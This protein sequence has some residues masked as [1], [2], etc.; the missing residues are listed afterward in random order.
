[1][2]S[3]ICIKLNN[4]TFF[5]F[6]S[7]T[8]ASLT[9][10]GDSLLISNKNKNFN[11]MICKNDIDYMKIRKMNKTKTLLFGGLGVIVYLLFVF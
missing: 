4:N 6:Y 10:K 1:M 2:N 9:E 8:H 3:I 5:N 11:E 7:G